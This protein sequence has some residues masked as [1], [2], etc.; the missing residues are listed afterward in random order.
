MYGPKEGEWL[1]EGEEGRLEEEYRKEEGGEQKL[2]RG[3]RGG[4][5][6]GKIRLIDREREKEWEQ[7][8]RILWNRARKK[9]FP[10]SSRTLTKQKGGR[11]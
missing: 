8:K 11:L 9:A 5:G 3:R 7:E 1:G 4:L 6:G 2:G 10:P